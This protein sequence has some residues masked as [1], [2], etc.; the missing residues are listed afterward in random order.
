MG[1][2]K[3]ALKEKTADAEEYDDKYF[4]RDPTDLAVGVRI[5]NLR[6]VVLYDISNEIIILNLE[7]Q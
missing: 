2:D 4:E 7:W 5:A 1:D 3:P 6:K